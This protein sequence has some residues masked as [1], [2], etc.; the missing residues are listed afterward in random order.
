[1]ILRSWGHVVMWSGKT[2]IRG[3]CLRRAPFLR[4]ACFRYLERIL[5]FAK[6][7][8]NK[9]VRVIEL[10]LKFY[11]LDKEAL[12]IGEIGFADKKPLIQ[13]ALF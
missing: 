3:S 9:I 6:C 5:G 12:I 7:I 2:F 8:V 10:S 1:M 11:F 13:K 4:Y